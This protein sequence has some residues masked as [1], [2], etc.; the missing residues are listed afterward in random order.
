MIFRIGQRIVCID[1]SPNKGGGLFPTWAGTRLIETGRI[2]TIRRMFN[3]RPFGHDDV[4]I[5]LEEVRNRPRPYTCARGYTVRCEQFWLGF[6]FRPLRTTSIE[7]F[8]R[9]LEP[10]PVVELVG[11]AT[12]R[13]TNA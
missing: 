12:E 13:P 9:M 10:V 6:R 3:A 8:T 2:Y 11:W 7:I 5:L 4:A 1:A